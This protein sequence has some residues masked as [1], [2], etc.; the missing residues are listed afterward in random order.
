M[1]KNLIKRYL[2]ITVIRMLK[3]INKNTI[4]FI[5]LGNHENDV[6]LAV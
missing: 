4:M 6:S 2:R 5:W 3:V 1:F